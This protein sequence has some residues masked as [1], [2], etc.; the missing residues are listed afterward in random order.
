MARKSLPDSIAKAA[1]DR[2]GN[3]RR[4]RALPAVAEFLGLILSNTSDLVAM[5]DTS[6]KRLYNNPAYHVLF[7][8]RD[9]VGTDSFRE[10]HPE[11][12]ERIR[13]IF[14]D[15][16]SSGIGRRT[17]YRFVL[18]DGSIEIRTAPGA[19]TTVR[20]MFSLPSAQG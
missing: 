1:V 16:V 17:Q 13:K 12:R 14:H 6:G 7:G 2:T 5:L 20:A 15:T 8:D 4:R 11:D 19:G 9:L 18:A 3:R 10:I